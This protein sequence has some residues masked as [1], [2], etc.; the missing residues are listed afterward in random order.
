MVSFLRRIAVPL[1]E[2][3]HEKLISNLVWI[4]LVFTYGVNSGLSLTIEQVV[5]QL[6][7]QVITLKAQVA[8]QNGLGDA[9]R[10]IENLATA[11]VRKDIPSLI[12]VTGLGRPKE[13][14]GKDEDLQ[15]WPKKTEGFFAGGS[16]ESEVMLE[17][18]AEQVTELTQEH[19]ELEFT[20]T[21]TNVEREGCST[22]GWCCS[23]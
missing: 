9:V 4:L 21:A 16:R 14:A 6:Q 23:T 8:D 13:F 20:P 1:S 3:E 15:H 22:W 18:S 12:D 5:T 7:Q 2:E 19:T 10:A 17:W 11:Q